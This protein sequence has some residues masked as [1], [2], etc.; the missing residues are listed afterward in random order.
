VTDFKSWMGRKGRSAAVIG[1]FAIGAYLVARGV[2]TL[3]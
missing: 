2:I 1:A 3:L